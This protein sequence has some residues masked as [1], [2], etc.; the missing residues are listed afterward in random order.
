L[1]EKNDKLVLKT[2][3]NNNL[4]VYEELNKGLTETLQNINKKIDNKPQNN[5]RMI[6]A[7]LQQIQEEINRLKKKNE[8][9]ENENN[10]I[11]ENSQYEKLLKRNQEL[12]KENE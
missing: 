12:K 11:L 2:Y 10:Q 3:E 5:S 6:S 4:F 8:K 7:Q 9:L 1:T